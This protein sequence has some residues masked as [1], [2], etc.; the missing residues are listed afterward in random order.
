MFARVY[1]ELYPCR[2]LNQTGGFKNSQ[3]HIRFIFSRLDDL[4]FRKIRILFFS[5]GIRT[6]PHDFHPERTV[7]ISNRTRYSDFQL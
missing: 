6:V 7:V 3:S 1:A 5:N 4:I 2:I